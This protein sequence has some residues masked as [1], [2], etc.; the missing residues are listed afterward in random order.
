MTINYIECA[1]VRVPENWTVDALRRALA[2]RN[3][4][5]SNRNEEEIMAVFGNAI[6]L[7]KQL[8][9]DIDALKKKKALLI[10]NLGKLELKQKSL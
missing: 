10:L 1:G 3:I 5:F 7:K 4:R 6:M 2:K 8:E 9:H